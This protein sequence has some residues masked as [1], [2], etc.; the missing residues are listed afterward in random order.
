MPCSLRLFAAPSTGQVG[1]LVGATTSTTG[2]AT[3]GLVS[4]SRTGT[5]WQMRPAQGTA[6]LRF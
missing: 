2:N 5:P 3:L 6:S 4:S 1:T